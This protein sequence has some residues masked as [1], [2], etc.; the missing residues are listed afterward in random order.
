MMK[1]KE[2]TTAG[3]DEKKERATICHVIKEEERNH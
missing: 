2:R 3:H 1:R